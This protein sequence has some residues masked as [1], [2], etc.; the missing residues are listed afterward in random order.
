MSVRM[1]LAKLAAFTAGGAVIG[2]GAVHVAENAK[3]R[4]EF[5]KKKVAA[6]PV[7]RRPVQ[8]VAARTRVKTPPMPTCAP[9]VVTVSTQ[10]PPVP[11][12]PR[13]RCWRAPARPRRRP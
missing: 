8:R 1:A 13:R 3:P 5:S 2:G 9:T 10:S 11:L 7:K 4:T 12:P 6:K